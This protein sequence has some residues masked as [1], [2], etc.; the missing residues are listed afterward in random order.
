MSKTLTPDLSASEE[1]DYEQMMRQ[2]FDEIAEANAK[3]DRDQDEIERM[4][5]ETGEIL[6]KLKAA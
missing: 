2:M 6:A 4:K 1:L 3:M 5:A